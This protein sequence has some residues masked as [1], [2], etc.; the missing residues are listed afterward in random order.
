MSTTTNKTEILE[1]VIAT[2]GLNQ[3]DSRNLVNSAIECIHDALV[4]GDNITIKGFG[5]LKQQIRAEREVI[6]PS[7]KRKMTIPAKKTITF[8]ASSNLLD[9]MKNHFPFN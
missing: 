7:T 5:S 9:E 6:N 1:R 2:G 4:S 8:K 3:K